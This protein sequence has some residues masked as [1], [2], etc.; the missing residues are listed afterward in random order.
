MDRRAGNVVGQAPTTD[1]RVYLAAE[2]TFLAWIRTG[3]ALMGF[4]FILARFG[5]F[6]QEIQAVRGESQPQPF[7]V[8]I[9]FGVALLVIGVLVNAAATA[10]HV[11]LVRSLRDGRSIFN[12]PSRMAIAV[13]V[14]LAF[15]GL[16]MAL[17][18]VLVHLRT[19]SPALGS[20]PM[21]LQE[22]AGI[23][24]RPSD[25]SVD[26]TVGR[27]QAMF[28][29]RGVTVFAIVDHSGEAQK[30]GMKMLPTKLLIFGSPKAGTPLMV[31]APCIALDL[32]LKLSIWE[33]TAAEVWI[34]YNSVD[35]LRARHQLS[36]ELAQNI[37]VVSDLAQRAAE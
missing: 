13:A 15:V 10:H 5:L 34:S 3:L 30:V 32:P 28:R 17:Y 11:H 22:H 20:K 29:S 37:A 1:P 16:I 2:R 27:L 36:Q 18:L 7:G 35:Y 19:P 26:Q 21:E 14:T 24:D 23:V 31:A 12:R 25:H 6:L 33:D 9:W 4:G 8:S